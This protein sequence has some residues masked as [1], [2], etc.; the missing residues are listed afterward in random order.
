MRGAG[1]GSSQDDVIQVKIGKCLG[2]GLH[3]AQTEFI[4]ASDYVGYG[5]TRSAKSFRE[6][7]SVHLLGLHPSNK[8]L[9]FRVLFYGH[10][11]TKV[12]TSMS[13]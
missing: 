13:C 11:A 7:G 9:V 5:R 8:A 3:K 4:P 1:R 12:A 10:G 2:E 6:L